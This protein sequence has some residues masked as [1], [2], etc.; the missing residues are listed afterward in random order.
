[1]TLT[2]DQLSR[3]Q[4]RPPVAPRDHR[5]VEPAAARALG[6]DPDLMVYYFPQWHADERNSRM[7]G[8]GWTEWELLRHG[9][10][11]FPGHMQPKR[12]LWG[13]IDESDPATASRTV[14]AALDHG[15]TGFIVDWYW[16]DNAPFLNGFL[17]RGLLAADRIEEFRFAL[18]WANHDWTDLYPAASSQ[19][20][21]MLPAPNSRYHAKTAAIHLIDT[22]FAHPSYYTV[23]GGKYFSV[24]DVM[25]FVEGL[26]GVEGAAQFLSWFREEARSRG[27]GELHL[28]AIVTPNVSNPARLLGELGFDSTTNYTWWHHS[29]NGFDTFPTTAYGRAFAAAEQTWESNHQFSIPYFPNV[30]MGWDPTP[31]TVAWDHASE[32]GYPFTSILADNTPENVG[33]ATRAALLDAARSGSGVV[34]FNAW[35]EWTEG[36]YLEPD[37]DHGYQY[38][39][40][41]LSAREEVRRLLA[42]QAQVAS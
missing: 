17:D 1:M 25:G 40:A 31:R 2:N 8:E 23:D 30:T 27:A 20:A 6:E 28:N 9:Q 29:P 10:P 32:H 38:L 5:A 24:Y 22:Y 35:N 15:I 42:T 19:P 33:A 16:F 11:R 41:I 12:P 21:R 4:L 37:T 7:W 13:E 36:S 18:M 39:E 26:G 14:A 3:A 34:T